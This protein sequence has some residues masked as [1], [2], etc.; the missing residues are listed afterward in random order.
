[1]SEIQQA[2]KSALALDKYFRGVTLVAERLKEIGDLE[3]Y[4]AEARNLSMKAR[5]ELDGVRAKISEA[6]AQLADLSADI[7]GAREDVGKANAEAADI[8]ANAR[9]D[10]VE[11]KL[12]AEKQIATDLVAH[13]KELAEREAGFD[14]AMESKRIE[15]ADLDEQIED[16]KNQKAIADDALAQLAHKLKPTE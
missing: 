4:E 2:A 15:I 5:E 7:V 9:A 3:N 8:R 10:A 11:A 12:Q 13:E 16:R 1:M 14:A 6:E